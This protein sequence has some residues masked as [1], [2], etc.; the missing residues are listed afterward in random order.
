[1]NCVLVL[2]AILGLLVSTQCFEF[3]GD[4]NQNREKISNITVMGSV[5]CDACSASS[6]SNHS[7]FLSGAQVRINCNF[8]ANSKSR[9]EI[10]I[11]ADKTTDQNGIYILQIPPID[12]FE[13]KTGREIQSFCHATLIGNSPS[14]L[15]NIPF[16]TVSIEHVSIKTPQTNSCVYNLNALYYRPD[17]NVT[18]CNSKNENEDSKS[19]NLN[20]SLFFWPPF[21]FH[22]PW[23]HSPSFPIPFFTPPP[24]WKVPLPPLPFFTP[25]P[26]FWKIPFPP[27]PFFTPPPPPPFWHLPPL[28]FLTPPPPP[29]SLPPFHLPPFP[30]IFTKP[31][32]PASPPPPEFHFPFPFPPIGSWFAPPPPPPL[33]PPP[34]PPEFHFPFPPVK[35]PP[36]FPSPDTPAPPPAG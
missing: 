20:T 32:Q 36:V 16:L 7:Y 26:P 35:F 17:K 15:C 9:E 29:P 28:P 21:G 5:F 22:W 27:L 24:F 10:S 19:T 4:P 30:P 25:P 2:V 8:R 12:G 18:T 13:C 11:T 6:F 33:P 3:E 23:E 34:P 1:M 14:S 31:P